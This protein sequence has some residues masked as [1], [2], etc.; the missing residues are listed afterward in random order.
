MDALLTNLIALAAYF[1]G[2]ITTPIALAKGPGV[3]ARITAGRTVLAYAY[4]AKLEGMTT[5]DVLAAYK[6]RKVMVLD[7]GTS[8]VV[9]ARYGRGRGAAADTRFVVKP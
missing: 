9:M 7:Y 2:L 3:V 1:G 4:G 6:A 8:I 5:T